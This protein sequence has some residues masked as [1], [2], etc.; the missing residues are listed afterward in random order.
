MKSKGN[1]VIWFAL[2]A[3][4]L[5]PLAMA[6]NSPLLQWR[7]PIYI[8]AGLAGVFAVVL[9]LFQP[10]LAAA[11][12]PGIDK[13]GSRRLHRI[14]GA[15]LVAT[16]IIH[17]VCLW[18]TSP[19]DVLDA[20]LFRSA[21]SFSIWGVIAMWGIFI[22][23]LLAASRRIFRVRPRLWRIAHKTLAAIIVVTSVVHAILIDGT[24]ETLSKYTLCAAVIAVAFVV[25]INAEV[26]T[27]HEPKHPKKH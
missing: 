15:L 26:T 8:V 27:L 14:V 19:P 7:E 9:L 11:Y 4:A 5:V 12:L 2:A 21:T 10:L 16:I 20:L 23:A 13:P 25:I 18:I 17:V 22:T 6:A 3:A 1:L 24:M